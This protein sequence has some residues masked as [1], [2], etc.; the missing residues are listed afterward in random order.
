MWHVQEFS[1]IL[2]GPDLPNTNYVYTQSSFGATSYGPETTIVGPVQLPCY[3]YTDC[4]AVPQELYDS[5]QQLIY[6]YTIAQGIDPTAFG[7]TGIIWPTVRG[8][9]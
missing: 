4:S 6:N 1:T 2:F 3:D 5:W 9:F 7:S 8:F